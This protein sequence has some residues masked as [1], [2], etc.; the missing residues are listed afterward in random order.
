MQIPG[1]ADAE[2]GQRSPAKTRKKALS[3]RF[4]A[5]KHYEQALYGKNA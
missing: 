4:G 5:M 1:R 3:R 2:D